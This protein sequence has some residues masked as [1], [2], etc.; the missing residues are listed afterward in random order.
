MHVWLGW[1]R[2]QVHK[3][4]DPGSILIRTIQLNLI[5]KIIFRSDYI[6]I[7]LCINK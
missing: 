3:Q 1:L 6:Y 5:Y 4:Y 2:R 7:Y